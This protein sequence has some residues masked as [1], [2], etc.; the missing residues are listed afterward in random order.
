MATPCIESTEGFYFGWASKSDDILLVKKCLV[1]ICLLE[2]VYCKGSLNVSLNIM[3][4]HNCKHYLFLSLQMKVTFTVL[5]Y[6]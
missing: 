6:L 2:E 4:K 5:L 3:L 1:T